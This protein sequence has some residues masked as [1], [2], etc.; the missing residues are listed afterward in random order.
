[1][2]RFQVSHNI[3]DK[4]ILME[5][6][7]YM[8][9]PWQKIMLFVTAIVAVI[10]AFFNFVAQ[11][12]LMAI[13]LV[14]L[15][16]MVIF[17]IFW[18]RYNQINKILKTMLEETGKDSH[19]YTLNFSRDSIV[20]HNCDM[21]SDQKIEY[22]RIKRLVETKNTYTIFAKGNQFAIIRKEALKINPEELVA[23]LKQKDTKI[24]KWI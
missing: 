4:D 14:L 21:A 3:I 23:F 19:V 20:I 18:L 17:E 22:N 24:K 2:E 10:F 7:K 6:K 13:I 11:D 15:G 9:A 16:G 1:M 12:Y 8:L 5:L